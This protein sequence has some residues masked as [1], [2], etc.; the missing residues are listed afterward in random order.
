MVQE[1]VEG[2]IDTGASRDYFGDDPA[3]MFVSILMHA[4]M[5]IALTS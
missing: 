4:E 5:W 1:E 3:N 2:F